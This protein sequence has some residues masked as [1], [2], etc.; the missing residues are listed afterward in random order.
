MLRHAFA[1]NLLASTGDLR[2]VQ[3]ALGHEDIA[4]TTIYTRI[5]IH[6]LQDAV[7]KFINTFPTEPQ[8]PDDYNR[9]KK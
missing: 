8:K 4:T 3:E 1:T 7:T 9:H 6:R 5:T 2:L